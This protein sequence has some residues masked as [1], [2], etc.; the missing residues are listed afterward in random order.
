MRIIH[1]IFFNILTFCL[2]AQ[3]LEDLIAI[4]ISNSPGIKARQMEVEATRKKIDQVTALPDPQLN[5]SIFMNAMMLPMGNQV[6]SIAAM[7]MF[8]WFGS[9]D[10]KAREVNSQVAVDQQMI[11]VTQNDLVY[12]LKLAFYPLMEIEEK[13]NIKKE[14]LK[15][16]LS[17]H[18]LASAKFQYA[19]GP[20]VNVIRA[21]MMID[22]IETEIS[23]LELKRKPLIIAINRI[24]NRPDETPVSVTEELKKPE[25]FSGSV[26]LDEVN[27]NPSLAVYDKKMEL[28][29]A[30]AESADFQRMPN[31]GAG[32]Q[33]ML[34]VQRKNNDINLLPNTGKDMIMPMVSLTIPIWKKK[35]DAAVQERQIMKTVYA[36]QKEEMKNE[37]AAIYAMSLYELQEAAQKIELIESQR[38]KT[39]QAIELLQASYQNDKGDFEEMLRLQQKLFSYQ[40]EEVNIKKEYHLALA[41]I[42]FLTGQP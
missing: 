31:I 4:A 23:L 12:R 16:I 28:S 40:L 32:L 24:L 14:N 7:Q 29:D 10:A 39:N 13:I 8:P 25:Q 38:I 3:T 20:M 41:K 35:Y 21:D 6:G 37:L 19:K 30:Q 27:G 5:G 42:E 17:D 15:I 11:A 22:E 9:L 1:I 36:S 18:E 26:H 34:Q 2:H 33:Y